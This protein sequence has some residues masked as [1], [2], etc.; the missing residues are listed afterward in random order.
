MLSDQLLYVCLP[1][2]CLFGRINVFINL[3]KKHFLYLYPPLLGLLNAL[4][5]SKRSASTAG[6]AEDY[7]P[8]MHCLAF[9]GRDQLWHHVMKC[10]FN[11]IS[12]KTGVDDTSS[13]GWVSCCTA[14]QLLL[15]SSL[16]QNSSRLE[17]EFKAAV[18]D[19][20]HR[21][22]AVLQLVTG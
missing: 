16:L 21:E 3:K 9:H 7:L 18:V 11:A 13:N 6:I 20:M 12:D 5:I 15:D 14:S 17:P 22:F 4:H 19:K 8:C 1:V 2:G 10:P